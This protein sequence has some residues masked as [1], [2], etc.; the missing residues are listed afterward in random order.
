MQTIDGKDSGSVVDNEPK[1]KI[2]F[3]DHY[4][5]F[6]FNVIDW[7][8]SSFEVDHGYFDQSAFLRKIYSQISTYSLLVLS[9]GPKS[10][11]DAKQ[12]LK[13]I[14]DVR[15]KIPILG[16]CLG[17]QLLAV[18]GGAATK[19]RAKPWHGTRKKICLKKDSEL[20]RGC[21]KEFYAAEYNSLTVDP[22]SLSSSWSI[23]AE[24]SEGEIEAID[25]GDR[26]WGLQFHPE[27]FMSEHKDLM[28]KNISRLV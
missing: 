23:L 10:P 12:T 24:D 8:S 1:R 5:S 19:K 26:S 11:Q 17:H 14:N 16:V 22:A 2:I 25:F 9:P 20:F 4:D 3:L 13:L 21:P 7:L 15:G 27:S 28:R 6:S 18:A